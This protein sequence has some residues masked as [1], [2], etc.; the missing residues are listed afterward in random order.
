MTAMLR[1][2][3][4]F[5]AV[6]LWVAGLLVLALW[7]G[8]SG[9][10]LFDD[11]ANL[12]TLGS[13]G[14]VEQWDTLLLYLT[15]GQADPLG[16]PLAMASFLVDAHNWPAE[17]APFLR[18]NLLL[19]SANAVLVGWLS[20]ALLRSAEPL[21]NV[22]R[23]GLVAVFAAGLW[24]LH[25]MH[26]T[27]ALYIIQ[28][29]ALL[30]TFFCLAGLLAFVA[31]WRAPPRHRLLWAAGFFLAGLA[32]VA[33]KANGL[34]LPVLAAA[35]LPLLNR[36]LNPVQRV[37]LRPW[38]IGL[39]FLPAGFVVALL[40]AQIPRAIVGAQQ[41][42]DFSLAE[43]LLAQ[44]G[45]LCT[46]LGHLFS[47]ARASGD[48]MFDPPLV[49]SGLADPT[50]WLPFTGLCLVSLLALALWRRAPLVATAWGFYLA[51]HLIESGPVNLELAF[52]HRN[53][54]P[55]ALLFLPLLSAGA[56][57][58][59]RP[60]LKVAAAI[61]V[62]ATLAGVLHLEARLWGQP[63]LLAEVWAARSPGSE[64][65]QVNAA[66]WD[67]WKGDIHQGLARLA[68]W[69][70]RAAAST[71]V[72]LTLL[73]LECASGRVSPA[74]SL[75]VLS[76]MATD[77]RGLSLSTSMLSIHAAR[78]AA[79]A[80]TAPSED[81]MLQAMTRNPAWTTPSARLDLAFAA[82][83]QRAR[84]NDLPGARHALLDQRLPGFPC[85]AVWRGAALLAE[86]GGKSDALALI[87][88][89]APGCEHAPV[90]FGMPRLHRWV[91]RLL[92]V[93][94]KERSALEQALR[95]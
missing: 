2:S 60:A 27:T 4:A 88:R 30:S 80:D 23:S 43:R 81:S 75:D 24:A 31:L 10:F 76:A 12:P 11:Y 19:H 92:G 45:V 52:A 13:F 79:C 84:Q 74:L 1:T 36:G 42:R 15:S 38:A 65:A 51:G 89:R 17:P 34:L 87:E 68:P 3:A 90:P 22:H 37:D 5:W 55:A 7:P 57:V 18:S 95:E 25:P 48:L 63:R 94:A 61:A 71:Q 33:S 20:L 16:R 49:P 67:V 83:G 91:R 9:S 86:N 82:A 93:D 77:K 39:A 69:R 26:G 29:H 46:Y 59:V 40:L 64:R 58:T 8:L 53:Y 56:Q 6:F 14:P 62:T 70:Y 21:G 32:A 66:T 85:G 54:L 44:P 73:D 78:Y 72:A 41:L 47:A 35:L 50:F 28:R